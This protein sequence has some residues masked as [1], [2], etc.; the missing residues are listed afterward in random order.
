MQNDVKIIE[1]PKETSVFKSKT[2]KFAQGQQTKD[3]TPGPG[4]YTDDIVM[5][6][7]SVK[8][9]KNSKETSK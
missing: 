6:K 8:S 3:L 5:G 9:P 7:K 4:F 1:V 2:K